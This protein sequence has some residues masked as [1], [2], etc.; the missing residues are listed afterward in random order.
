VELLKG[1]W[2]N[3]Q[4]CVGNYKIIA[5]IILHMYNGRCSVLPETSW[6][7]SLYAGPS[8]G[9]RRGSFPG[10]ATFWGPHHL[11]KILKMVFQMAFFLTHICIKSIFS[12][13]PA[14]RAYDAPQMVRGHP[15]PR[16]VSR[17][18]ALSS[19]GNCDRAP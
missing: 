15:S 8:R 18:I 14:G 17:R 3:S 6:C 16:F 1:L 9:G 2:L 11:S 19:Y 7:S 12:P 5:L 4:E 13:H 10:P